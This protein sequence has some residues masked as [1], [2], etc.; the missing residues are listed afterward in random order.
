[1]VS[2]GD[3]EQVAVRIPSRLKAKLEREA[4][5]REAS[6]SEYIRNILADRHRT[7]ELEERMAIRE[8][9]IDELETQ[10]A[11]LS[12]IQEKIED[13]PDTIHGEIIYRDAATGCLTNPH[14]H[15]RPMEGDGRSGRC[16]RLTASAP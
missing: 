8:E 16:R 11:E 10:L 15:S 12:Q 4:D 6:R 1:M 13:L 9:R 5:E 3:K 7:D 14:S 2:Q